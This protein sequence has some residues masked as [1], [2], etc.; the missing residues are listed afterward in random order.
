MT[1]VRHIVAELGLTV[2]VDGPT[3]TGQALVVPEL[4]IP[5]TD[6]LRT[7][8]IATWADVI[9]GTLCILA[10]APRI[11]LTLDLE[12]QVLEPP[13]AGDTVTMES[14]IVK[15]G[16]TVQVCEARFHV[17]G[18]SAPAALAVA[19]FIASPDPSHV[20][21]P[22][23]RPPLDRNPGRLRTPLAERAN[24]TVLAPGVA[25]VPWQPDGLNAAGGIQGGLLTLAA[26]Q[27]AASL[28]TAPVFL[29]SLTFRYLRQFTVGPARATAQ[30]YGSTCLVRLADAGADRLGG[31][32]TA[33]LADLPQRR[34]TDAAVFSSTA[35]TALVSEPG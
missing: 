20:F 22:D 29:R 25:E 28:G 2:A 5:G 14:T 11:P 7:S 35:T 10:L 23:F 16:R 24:C 21:P 34:V 27:A 12:V 33:H 32:A 3:A 13:T 6:A 31:L 26:E 4:C 17:A 18:S 30:R 8:V 1:K 15:Q 19:S 9:T